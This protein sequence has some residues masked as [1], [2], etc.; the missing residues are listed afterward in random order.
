MPLVNHVRVPLLGAGLTLLMFLPGIIRQGEA[1][2]LAATGL[3]QAPYLGR[4]LGLVAALFALSALVYAVRV[5]PAHQ[6]VSS[7]WLTASASPACA[8]SQPR[9][10][11]QQRARHREPHR[12]RQPDPLDL[13]L[14]HPGQVGEQD[15]GQ[16]GAASSAA[17]A[18]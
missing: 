3:D 10:A 6:T 4:W 13:G 7:R 16:R 2:H 18:R 14:A 5:R 11:G 9:G 15:R 12:E 1:T 8:A 17:A